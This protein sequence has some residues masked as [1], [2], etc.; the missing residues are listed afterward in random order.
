MLLSEHLKAQVPGPNGG[1]W[2]INHRNWERILKQAGH[3]SHV[4]ERQFNPY[5]HLP[6]SLNWIFYLRQWWAK[7]YKY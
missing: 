2:V 7:F 5:F 3:E 4:Q 6:T 1:N